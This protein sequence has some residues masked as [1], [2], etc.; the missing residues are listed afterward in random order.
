MKSFEREEEPLRDARR[1]LSTIAI[2]STGITLIY[3]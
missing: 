3:T 1:S 2:N